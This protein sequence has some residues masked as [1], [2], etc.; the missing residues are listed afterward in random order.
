MLDKRVLLALAVL[1]GAILA[2]TKEAPTASPWNPSNQGLMNTPC[3]EGVDPAGGCLMTPTPTIAWYARATHLPDEPVFTPTPDPPRVVPTLRLEPDQYV[4]Q[5]GDTLGSVASRYGV[6]WE[7]IAQANQIDDPNAV[8]VGQN[9]LIPAPTPF[10]KAPDF[11]II[12]DSE[13]V[14]GPASIIFDLDEFLRL[15][16]GYLS[17]YT[18]EIDGQ[19]YSGEQVLQRVALEYS[20]NPRILLSALEYTSGWV[21]HTEVDALHRQYP[22]G[23]IND[24]YPGLYKQ[25]S[26]AASNLNR[27]FYLWQ[28]NGV[29]AWLLADGTRIP[30]DPTINAGTAGV[31]QLMAALYGAADWEQAVSASGLFAVYTSLFGYPFDLAIEPLLP[32][33]LQQPP[34]ALPFEPGVDW[35]FTGGP[36]SGWGE[37]S[38]WAALDFA[39]PGEPRGCVLSNAWVTAVANGRVIYS[40]EGMVIEDLDG[41]GFLQTGWS[42]LYLHLDAQDR[43]TSGTSLVTGDRIGHPSCAGGVSSGTHLHIARR[44]NGAWISADGAIPFNLDGWVSSGADV[45]YEGYLTKNGNRI[46]ALDG[47]RESNQIHR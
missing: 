22:L 20:V 28:V 14:Y 12:P 3:P 15:H 37:G 44:Y 2:C 43:V 38:G 40:Q 8:S 5:A 19:S 45:E 23:Y 35:S 29:G 32:A 7:T 13:L 1:G 21:T 18:E 24:R 10:G 27:G 26:F 17:G 6:S 30:V 25:L 34:L 47:V 31:Q 9:I 41:D 39:P 11:K 16:S 42:V 4:I 33:D 36:H 46:E